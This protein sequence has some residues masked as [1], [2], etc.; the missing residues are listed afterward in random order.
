MF[1]DDIAGAFVLTR[2]KNV[3]E[4]LNDRTMLRGPDK[5]DPPGPS[6]SGWSEGWSRSGNGRA[7]VLLNPVHGRAAPF[8]RAS[9]AGEGPLRAR[10]QV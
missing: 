8:A 7:A 1:R 4:T 10:R 9:A 2:F 6:P 5:V 3:R